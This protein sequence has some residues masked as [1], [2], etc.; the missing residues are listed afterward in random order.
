MNLRILTFLSLIPGVL[1]GLGW[2]MARAVLL[3]SWPVANSM[4]TPDIAESVRKAE[5]YT[6]A[7]VIIG[8]ILGSFIFLFLRRLQQKR[9][10]EL[11]ARQRE[12][13]RADISQAISAARIAPQKESEHPDA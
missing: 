11:H 9:L 5:L 3:N 8:A 7:A 13:L 4:N 6:V 2:I 12:E 1:P 10:E